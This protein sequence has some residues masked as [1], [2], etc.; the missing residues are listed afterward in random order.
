MN[1][2]IISHQVQA[3]AA[4]H[5]GRF[6]V[7]HLVKVTGKRS[8]RSIRTGDVRAF[9][10]LKSKSTNRE[11]K[12]DVGTVGLVNVETVEGRLDEECR[13]MQ[14]FVGAVQIYFGA[15]LAD[16][17]KL[18]AITKVGDNGEDN[19]PAYPSPTHGHARRLPEPAPAEPPVD[20]PL[21]PS[22]ASHTRA[23][24][25]GPPAFVRIASQQLQRAALLGPQA[26][27]EL[28]G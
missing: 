9:T 2:S 20:T 1:P 17:T 21:E 8:R 26:V 6:F 15:F 12:V 18:P 23:A 19:I 14:A 24:L 25:C 7:R 5:P 4:A 27:M 22:S 13:A 10:D 28:N 16:A 3:F 11:F